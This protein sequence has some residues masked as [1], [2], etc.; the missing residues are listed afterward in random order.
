MLKFV[1]SFDDLKDFEDHN[2]YYLR[3]RIHPNYTGNKTLA[4]DTYLQKLRFF[5]LDVSRHI[6]PCEDDDWSW[7]DYLKREKKIVQYSLMREFDSVLY[8]IAKSNESNDIQVLLNAIMDG[9]ALDVRKFQFSYTHKLRLLD[10]DYADEK[11]DRLGIYFDLLRKELDK[12]PYYS[13]QDLIELIRLAYK[14]YPVDSITLADGNFDIRSPTSP[15]YY[16]GSYAVFP[17]RGTCAWMIGL[18]HKIGQSDIPDTA[19]AI[20]IDG[21]NTLVVSNRDEWFTS[22]NAEHVQKANFLEIA[23]WEKGLLPVF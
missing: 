10:T 20:D 7:V 13:K 22:F 23:L 11:F 9:K 1:S 16:E 14:H 2:T 15:D 19:E 17:H 3:I 5:L 8:Q 6:Q 18:P 21:K 4:L 12:K